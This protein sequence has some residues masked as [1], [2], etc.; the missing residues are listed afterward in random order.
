MRRLL[1]IAGLVLLSTLGI[2]PEGMFAQ[3]QCPPV[4]SIEYPFDTSVFKLAQA[5]GVP[6]PRHQGRYHTG[7]DWTAAR[8]ATYGLEVRAIANG[9][10]TYSWPLGWGRDGGV[11]IIE[12]TLP[13]GSV[14]YSQYGHLMETDSIKFPMNLTCVEQGQVIA[15]ITDARPA[16]HIHFEIRVGGGADTPGPGY[17]WTFPDDNFWRNPSRFIENYQARSNPA[18]QWS[19]AANN[20]RG[21]TAPPLLLDD[22]SLMYI[23]G[24]VL[25]MATYDGR[26][27]WRR[28]L[29]VPA[30]A[31]YGYQRNPYL[32]IETGSIQQLDYEGNPQASWSLPLESGERL[33]AP[34]YQAGDAMLFYT[35]RG[36]LIQLTDDRRNIAWRLDDVP[37][38]VR[39]TFSERLIGVLTQRGDLLTLSREGQLIDRVRLRDG[40]GMS[41]ADSLR[42]FSRGG[43][44]RIDNDG[45]WSLINEDVR[46]SINSA[47]THT[48][49]GRLMA[50]DGQRVAVFSLDGAPGGEQSAQ[51]ITDRA[52]FYTIDGIGLLISTGGDLLAFNASGAQC[53]QL[54]VYGDGSGHTWA[55]P[56][57]DGT[58]R[59]MIGSQFIGVDWARFT[60][61]CTL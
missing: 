45:V 29:D 61:R 4:D 52:D 28:L 8:G 17:S 3:T 10:V 43:L 59:A 5:Y 49:D 26:V 42:V 24:A 60:Q 36:A 14:F 35:S 27:L 9:R 6:S 50:Y 33:L 55:Q 12:H 25:R 53:A 2:V 41:G 21:F 54:R 13:D 7:E 15:A 44:W 37:Q 38:P 1:M 34:A 30:V 58:L 23:D 16:P 31:V 51:S 22:N 48:A 46:A 56:G 18:F 47:L 19:L 32:V 57:S 11:I 20:L 39:V 40:A